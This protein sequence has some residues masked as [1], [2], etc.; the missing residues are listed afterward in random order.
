MG[1]HKGELDRPAFEASLDELGRAGYEL[2]WVF[3]DQKLHREKDSHVLI[4]KRRV[5]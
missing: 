1:F 4:F 2:S 3:M 5:S